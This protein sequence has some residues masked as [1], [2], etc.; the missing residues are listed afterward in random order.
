[1]DDEQATAIEPEL[2]EVSEK[3]I[4]KFT[5]EFPPETGHGIP[6]HYHICV[7]TFDGYLVFNCCTSQSGKV[8]DRIRFFGRTYVELTN[9]KK[10]QF[11]MQ[12]FVDCDNV[13]KVSNEEFA[14][15]ITEGKVE[16]AGLISAAD[17][18]RIVCGILSSEMVEEGT[19]KLF[20]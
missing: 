3:D 18:Q 4:Y 7:K 13:F 14:K 5:Q 15:Y 8:K 12:T 20:K 10:T 9:L 16:F 11:T 19:K 2:F 6:D 17:Y 1:M